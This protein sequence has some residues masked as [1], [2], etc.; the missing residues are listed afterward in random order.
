MHPVPPFHS[1]S[2]RR[3]RLIEQS[4]TSKRDQLGFRRHVP[5]MWLDPGAPACNAELLPDI[6]NARTIPNKSHP[7]L[8]EFAGLQ[9]CSTAP[10]PMGKTDR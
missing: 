1:F 2:F 6:P 7:K 9:Q 5:G 8:S 3:E 10:G 4:E